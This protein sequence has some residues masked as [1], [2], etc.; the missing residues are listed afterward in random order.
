MFAFTPVFVVVISILSSATSHVVLD[1]GPVILLLLPSTR[2]VLSV[3]CTLPIVSTISVP[4]PVCADLICLI[5]TYSSS[6]LSFTLSKAVRNGSPSPLFGLVP[7]LI[8]CFAITL[9]LQLFQLRPCQYFLW[10][11][12]LYQ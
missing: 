7:K 2:S 12:L 1:I 6:K 9:S 5:S 4:P 10:L 11:A 3:A 8:V